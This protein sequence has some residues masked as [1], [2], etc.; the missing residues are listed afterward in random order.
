MK[1]TTNTTVDMNEVDMNEVLKLQ[2]ERD[3]MYAEWEAA[4]EV[5]SLTDAE[6]ASMLEMLWG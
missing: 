1:T 3:A 6:A 2:A 5:E 4:E